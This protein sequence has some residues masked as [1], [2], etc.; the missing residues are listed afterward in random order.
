[1]PKALSL[2]RAFSGAVTVW[3]IPKL[4]WKLTQHVLGFGLVIRFGQYHKEETE[5]NTEILG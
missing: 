4:P 5:H 1:M 3:L 2:N